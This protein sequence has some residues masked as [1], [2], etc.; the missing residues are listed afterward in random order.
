MTT[1]RT[2]RVRLRIRR[3]FVPILAVLLA[4]ALRTCYL[5]QV[6]P[7]WRDDELINIHALTGEVMQGRCPLYFTGA[8]GHEPLYHCL[9]AGVH[10]VLGFNVLSGHVLSATLGTLSV[11][12]TWTLTARMFGRVAAGVASLALATSFWSLMYS[13]IALRHISL[14]PPSLLAYYFLWRILDHSRPRLRAYVPLGVTLGV[15]LYTYFASRL[16]PV[17]FLA[18]LAYLLAFHRREFRRHWRGILL[19]VAVALVMFVPMAWVIGSNGSADARVSELAVPL[20]ELRAGNLLPVL[21]GALTTLRMF[22]AT[23]DPEWLYN[24][25]GRPVFDWLGGGF[26]WAGLGLCLL[27]WRRPRHFFLVIWLFVGLLPAFISVPPASLS[28]TILAQPVVYILPAVLLAEVWRW[29]HGLAARPV[30]RRGL[31]VVLCLTV[32][33]FLVTNAWRDLR[34]YFV[35]WPQRGM[36]RFLYRGDFRQIARYLDGHRELVDVAVGSSLMGPWD[37]LAL[38]VDIQRDDVFVR[39]FD[40]ERAMVWVGGAARPGVFLASSP[41]LASPLDALPET[42]GADRNHIG[43]SI[44]L[45][46]LPTVEEVES[47]M[48]G[49][50]NSVSAIEARFANGLELVSLCW[51]TDP[52]VRQRVGSMLITRWRVATPLELPP[53]AIVANPPP[54][55]VY[56]GPRLAVFSHLLAADG[57]PIAVDDGLW[58]DPVTLRPGDQFIQVHR[59]GVAAD[60]PEGSHALEIGLYDPKTG[61][62]LARVDGAADEADDRI[63]LPLGPPDRVGA[64]P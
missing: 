64:G 14:L 5:D 8:S 9:H 50:E 21:E 33:G 42:A 19:A 26:M 55:G 63:V 44:A 31:H 58:V 61:E 54:P 48:C 35:E 60:A 22:E 24:L 12:L 46:S 30:F 2:P 57:A 13:R 20:R 25:P 52:P 43:G 45:H 47:V 4:W 59:F 41:R 37:R 36:T 34:A 16:L 6:P 27:R 18:F 1:L 28:H 7:G 10:A 56:A 39:L 29:L 62:R 32:T 51:V 38:D 49:P 3:W 23:G 11:V 40:P 53:V 17:L 15:S